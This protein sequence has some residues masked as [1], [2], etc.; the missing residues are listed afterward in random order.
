MREGK[1]GLH[2]QRFQDPYDVVV[3]EINSNELI[4]KLIQ[5]E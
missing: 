1:L 4:T 2:T 3:D 5:K